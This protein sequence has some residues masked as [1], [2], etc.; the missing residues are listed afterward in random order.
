MSGRKTSQGLIPAVKWSP[1]LLPLLNEGHRL[2]IP[3]NGLSMF[4][5]LVGGRD[6]ALLS[7]VQDKKLKRGDI[8]LFV[9]EDGAHVLHRI[10]HI[11]KNDF[12]MLGDSQT[13]IEGPVSRENVLAMAESL[14][15]KDKTI[16]CSHPVYR[17]ASSLWLWVRPFRPYIFR[18]LLK[19]N[20]TIKHN[21]KR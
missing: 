16:S 13:T 11:I 14:I 19:L 5:L 18:I 9:Q 12:F 10:H 1:A 15:R 21:R 8:V 3:L 6:E 20:R 17:F 7:A 2:R 4:P